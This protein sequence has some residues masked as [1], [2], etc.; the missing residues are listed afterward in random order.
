MGAPA[1]KAAMR[2]AS[3]A[4]E[5]A[6]ALTGACCL[7]VILDGDEGEK[8]WR[9]VEWNA[10]TRAHHGNYLCGAWSATNTAH[11]K[12]ARKL[13]ARTALP[14]NHQRGKMGARARVGKHKSFVI[15]RNV[16]R[17]L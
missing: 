2:P 10:S 6:G 8:Q 7:V 16:A 4:A 5:G 13:R 11:K 17:G 14:P 3:A 9:C 12:R 1:A 15:V